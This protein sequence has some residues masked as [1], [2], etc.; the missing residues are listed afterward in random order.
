MSPTR[1]VCRQI[2][3]DCGDGR[4]VDSAPDPARRV[5]AA[6]VRRLVHGAQP[7]R[8]RRVRPVARTPG[9]R[10]RHVLPVHAQ[11]GLNGPGFQRP[12]SVQARARVRPAAVRRRA[13][14]RGGRRG[15][16]RARARDLGPRP[17]AAQ[18][19]PARISDGRQRPRRAA[20]RGRPDPPAHDRFDDPSRCRPAG[21]AGCAT[22]RA[23]SARTSSPRARTARPPRAILDSL[24]R[25]GAIVVDRSRAPTLYAKQNADWNQLLRGPTAGC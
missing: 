24:R 9:L 1:M 16:H 5:A 15:A 25:Y 18:L 11:V 17:R 23:R 4:N 2:P 13:A 19:R 14:A 3:P 12:N 20:A 7:A 21:R 22:A 8:G 6:A 10:R